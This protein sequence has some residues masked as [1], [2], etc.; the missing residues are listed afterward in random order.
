[1][2][3]SSAAISGD[4]DGRLEAYGT[5]GGRGGGADGVGI[6]GGGFDTG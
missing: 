4:R 3:I 6:D 2:A 5:A 1:M